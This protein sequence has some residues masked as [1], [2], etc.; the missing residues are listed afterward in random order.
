[1]ADYD[2]SLPVRTEN[3]GDIKNV[4]V[5]PT[6]TSQQLGVD[7]NGRLGAVIYGNNGTSDIVLPIDPTSGAVQVDIVDATGI[8]VDVDIDQVLDGDAVGATKGTIAAGTDGSNY[9]FLS[10]T[11]AGELKVDLAVQSLTAVAVSADGNANTSVNPI[12][13]S[14]VGASGDAVHEYDTSAS[15]AKDATHTGSYTVSVGKTL[16]LQQIRASGSGKI[17]VE[18]QVNSVTVD[19]GFNSTAN[20][21][22]VIDFPTAILVPAGQD[23][24]VI[25]T[26]RDGLAQD[27]YTSINGVEN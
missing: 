20:P 8:T 1:M 2:S 13:V 12:F 25:V 4:I 7:A 18:V 27:L 3:D 9:Q 11:T 22:V 15:I 5:D 19:V 26:N 6:T 21:D 16:S 14:D 24:D 10:T 23:V 17:K